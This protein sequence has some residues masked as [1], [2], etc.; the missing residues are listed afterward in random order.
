MKKKKQTTYG[1]IDSD[2]DWYIYIITHCAMRNEFLFCLF[3][4]LELKHVSSS[5]DRKSFTSLKWEEDINRIMTG[6]KKKTCLYLDISVDGLA[7]WLDRRSF[8]FTRL[9][10]SFFSFWAIYSC[11]TALQTKKNVLTT[12]NNTCVE[13]YKIKT[14][15]KVNIWNNNWMR[16]F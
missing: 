4:Y 10:F 11:D 14:V 6:K 13:K 16:F 5:V 3:I 8:H 15:E 1:K 7:Y 9:F 12:M 2:S